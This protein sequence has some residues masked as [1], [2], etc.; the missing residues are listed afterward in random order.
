M[1]K[2]QPSISSILP[3]QPDFKS[4]EQ[5]IWGATA[6]AARAELTQVLEALDTV[7]MAQRPTGEVRWRYLL[8]EALGLPPAV[9]VSPGLRDR[10]MDAAVRLTYRQAAAELARVRPDG[11]GPSHGAIHRWVRHVGEQRI[12]REAAEVRA[13]FAWILCGGAM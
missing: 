7:L 11:R 3:T 8:D 12:D 1:S 5:L 13:L 6:A 2:V 9:T 10:A 4:L